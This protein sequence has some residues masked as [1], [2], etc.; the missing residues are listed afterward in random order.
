MQELPLDKILLVADHEEKYGQNWF[1]CLTVEATDKIFAELE[2]ERLKEEEAARLKD[3]EEEKRRAAEEAE[4]NVVYKDLPLV[5]QPY[6][7]QTQQETFDEICEASVT[8]SRC[9]VTVLVR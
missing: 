1:V 7:S 6:S 8:V 5:P 9:A 2:A 3:E 4:R